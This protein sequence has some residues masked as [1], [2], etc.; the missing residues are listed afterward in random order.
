MT[1]VS[2]VDNPDDSLEVFT[3]M[4]GSDIRSLLHDFFFFFAS[5]SFSFLFVH[6]L[7]LQSCCA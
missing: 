1:V 5:F 4:G 7:H 2:S 3:A 6:T